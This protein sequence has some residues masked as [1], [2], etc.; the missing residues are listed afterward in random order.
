[1]TTCPLTSPLIITGYLAIISKN[2]LKKNKIVHD[3]LP[4]IGYP[5]HLCPC[6]G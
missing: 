5:F 3:H 6:L 2:A 1:M 4:F